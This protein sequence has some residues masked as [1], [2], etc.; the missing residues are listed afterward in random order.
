MWLHCMVLRPR[1][2]PGCPQQSP[3]VP[4][5][6]CDWDD[7]RRVCS[8]KIK[9]FDLRSIRHD[10][11]REINASYRRRTKKEDNLVELKY[12]KDTREVYQSLINTAK[13]L[14]ENNGV[15]DPSKKAL[16][17]IMSESVTVFLRK[18][19]SGKDRI[20]YKGHLPHHLRRQRLQQLHHGSTI[21]PV[22]WK[23]RF[24]D[25]WW[26]QPSEGW[27]HHS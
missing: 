24:I 15:P 9:T 25:R 22:W 26:I 12:L 10:L 4:W 5:R 16:L 7:K 6:L 8:S 11:R 18:Y 20:R 2:K 27:K 21:R 23:N 1:S 19:P 17:K 14:K 13:S 3:Q